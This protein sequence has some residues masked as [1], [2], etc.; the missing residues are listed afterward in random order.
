MISGNI[1]IAAVYIIVLLSSVMYKTLT[2]N[3]FMYKM[4]EININLGKFFEKY[5]IFH[6]PVFLYNVLLHAYILIKCYIFPLNTK[7]ISLFSLKET[8]QLVIYFHD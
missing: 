7:Q 3:L 5:F 6:I 1:D 8:M 2:K 4:F